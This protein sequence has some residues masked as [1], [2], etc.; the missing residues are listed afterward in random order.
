MKFYKKIFEGMIKNSL[1]ATFLR[2]ATL[3]FRDDAF[4]LGDNTLDKLEF[5]RSTNLDKEITS[6]KFYLSLARSFESIFIRRNIAGGDSINV[7]F[8]FN[9]LLKYNYKVVPYNFF[10][11]RNIKIKNELEERVLSNSAKIENATKYIQRAYII[12]PETVAEKAFMDVLRKKD[13]PH[14]RE[15]FI[16]VNEFLVEAHKK[17]VEV[18]FYINTDGKNTLSRN[19]FYGKDQTK[20]ELSKIAEKCLDQMDDELTKILA[21]GKFEKMI[22]YLL[23]DR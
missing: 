12:I 14:S 16:Y 11:E 1:H 20:K 19:F 9:D 3:I 6:Y 2:N 10:S 15:N 5:E 21:K 8:E 23:R 7:V 4:I 13:Q 17:G 18:R 22:N